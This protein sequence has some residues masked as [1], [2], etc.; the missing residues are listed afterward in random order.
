MATQGWTP[1]FPNIFHGIAGAWD[2]PKGL[3][4]AQRQRRSGR[5]E[6][7]PFAAPWDDPTTALALA[8]ERFLLFLEKIQDAKCL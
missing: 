7:S 4:P 8:L 2:S 1:I 6:G 3:H 5:I